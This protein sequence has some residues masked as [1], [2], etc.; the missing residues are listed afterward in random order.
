M[1][2]RN[3]FRKAAL[4]TVIIPIA[5]NAVGN[6]THTKPITFSKLETPPQEYLRISCNGNVGIGTTKPNCKLDMCG[7]VDITR[8]DGQLVFNID[9][10]HI[11]TLPDN[12]YWNSC[13]TPKHQ[14]HIKNV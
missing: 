9:N 6:D 8:K 12:G 4:A 13:L 7:N 10:K 1:N 3:F 5:L 11:L 2:R 14:L